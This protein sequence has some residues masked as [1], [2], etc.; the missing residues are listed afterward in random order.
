MRYGAPT[1]V[2]TGPAHPGPTELPL[3]ET[4]WYF[5]GDHHPGNA[6]YRCKL[7]YGWEKLVDKE[8]PRGLVEAS[9]VVPF[10]RELVERCGTIKA[11]SRAHDLQYET[12]RALLAGER[13]KL[14]KQTVA[15]Y[16]L[17]LGEQRKYDRR[18]GLSERFHEARRAQG[19]R[20]ARLERLAG[21]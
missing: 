5:H 19:E 17:A 15:R 3:T 13:A 4:Y 11:A 12:L 1:K 8:A 6:R 21:Y 2:C 14:K 16:L 20:E 18:N 9:S 10:A 7:C